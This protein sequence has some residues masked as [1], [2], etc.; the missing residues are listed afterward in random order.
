MKME[1]GLFTLEAA[2]LASAFLRISLWKDLLIA[3]L[4]FPASSEMRELEEF[5]LSTLSEE[6]LLLGV[7]TAG[8]I[9]VFFG[10]GLLIASNA[11]VS[12]LESVVIACFSPIG[13]VLVESSF[14]MLSTDSPGGL[15]ESLSDEITPGFSPL[16]LFE[17]FFAGIIV[18]A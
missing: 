5:V 7:A 17:L 10:F 18:L 12:S 11:A 15:S 13:G 9:G 2:S 16:L 14:G 3:S 4:L 8:I 1:L 6:L